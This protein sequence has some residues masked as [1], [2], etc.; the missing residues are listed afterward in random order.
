MSLIRLKPHINPLIS[1]LVLY[2]LPNFH[3]NIILRYSDRLKNL[4]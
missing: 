2:F 3:I 1:I 4:Y